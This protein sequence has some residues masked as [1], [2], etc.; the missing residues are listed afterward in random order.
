[1]SR[2]LILGLALV[3]AGLIL[4]TWGVR[5]AGTWLV[6]ADRLQPARAVV[7]FGGQVPFRAME[8]A[9]IYK[10]GLAREVWLTPGGVYEEDLALAKLD[11]DRP[12]EY[13]YSEQVLERLEV[14]HDAIRVLPGLTENTADEVRAVARE[15]KQVG[16]DRAIVV[17]SKYHTRRV[18]VLW[19]ALVGSRPELVVRYTPADP[20]DA[21]RWWRTSEDMRSVWREWFGLLNAWAGFP[22]SSER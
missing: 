21:A 5:A 9:A 19:R 13:M 11:I 8:A 12:R 10:Q 3:G 20:F 15:L 4:A 18:R 1:M 6:V 7:V 16:G 14:P 17:T 2:R 22:V